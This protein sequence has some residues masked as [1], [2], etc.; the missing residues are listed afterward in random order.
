MLAIRIE[1]AGP[2]GGQSVPLVSFYFHS[3][4]KYGLSTYHLGEALGTEKKILASHGVDPPAA[5]ME[6]TL[7]G[8]EV[9]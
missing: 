8:Q 9:G 4:H 3:S 6:A 5:E 7:R 1:C 2:L